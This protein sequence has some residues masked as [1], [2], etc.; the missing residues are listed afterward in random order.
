MNAAARAPTIAAGLAALAL[1]GLGFWLFAR[2]GYDWRAVLDGTDP[3]TF[4]GLM[5]TLPV[6]G[7]PIS[8]CYIYAGLAFDWPTAAAVC[9]GGLAVNMTGSYLLMRTVFRG[10]LLRLFARRGWQVPKLE[11]DRLFRFVFLVR[12][13]PGPPFFFQNLA[14]SVAGIP[15]WT[16]LWMSLLT[17]G[18]I[19]LGVIYCSGVLSR[20]PSS[21][22]GIVALLL[23]GLL[24]VA[25][26]VRWAARR[27]RQRSLAVT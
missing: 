25:K 12:T 1:G 8:A 6:V 2:A 21:V 14:L 9:W 23:I 26:T 5:A 10:P 27:R 24:L 3:W 13:V 19:A 18:S 7:F 11:G 15:F 16:Y 22:G 17:Q 4:F 20:D